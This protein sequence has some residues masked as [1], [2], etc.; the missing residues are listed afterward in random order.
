[1]F[2]STVHSEIIC[3]LSL[4]NDP[5]YTAPYPN[6]HDIDFNSFKTRVDFQLQMILQNL[7]KTSHRKGGRR[8]YDRKQTE[9]DVVT[10]RIRY[11]VNGVYVV[12]KFSNKVITF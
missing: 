12:S 8:K 1:M 11:N 4:V 2:T 3:I 9:L 5:V 6:G 7:M 10:T